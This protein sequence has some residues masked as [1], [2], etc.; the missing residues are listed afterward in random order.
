MKMYGKILKKIFGAASV[1]VA[2]S[3]GSLK[4]DFEN[5]LLSVCKKHK[6]NPA[7][8]GIFLKYYKSLYQKFKENVVV[9]MRKFHNLRFKE[10]KI[11]DDGSVSCP[12]ESEI[13]MLQFAKWLWGQVKSYVE[14]EERDSWNDVVKYECYDA[15][16]RRICSF[17]FAC[18]R[19]S[20]G[21]FASVKMS[22][23]EKDIKSEEK[24]IDGIM[25]S[26]PADMRDYI[27]K[28]T[29]CNGVWL[30]R[31][32]CMCDREKKWGWKE[33]TEG[34]F[35]RCWGVL[36]Y[37]KDCRLY[38]EKFS[39]QDFDKIDAFWKSVKGDANVLWENYKIEGKIDELEKEKGRV[40]DELYKKE[41]KLEYF[42]TWKKRLSTIAIVTYNER[43]EIVSATPNSKKDEYNTGIGVDVYNEYR[44][45]PVRVEELRNM[46]TSLETEIT[47]LEE[48]L[49]IKDRKLSEGILAFHGYNACLKFFFYVHASY[50]YALKEKS[51]F[52][53]TF[54]E[55][56]DSIVEIFTKRRCNSFD[57]SVMNG[58]G[59]SGKILHAGKFIKD[60]KEFGPI[61]QIDRVN[62]SALK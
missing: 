7:E 31:L 39:D 50:Q 22:F 52:K 11:V 53:N 32:L 42:E 18:I 4:A 17:G 56:Y 46:K 23:D 47:K 57:G 38:P 34:I 26:F 21:R 13:K 14:S 60:D 28:E 43:G 59:K 45:V 49:H 19:F 40:V 48:K 25:E 30:R 20:A 8:I 29:F 58:S 9:K 55:E 33:Y 12:R 37:V 44:F 15:F 36:D 24:V 5:D 27:K 3:S 62:K 54:E 41:S 2:L 51:V 16:M 6:V 61:D 10:K 35:N 1:C